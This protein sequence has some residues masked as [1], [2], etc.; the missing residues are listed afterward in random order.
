MLLVP[1][2]MEG[3]RVPRYRDTRIPSPRILQDMASFD[4]NDKMMI[5]RCGRS[6]TIAVHDEVAGL[7]RSCD[8]A[9]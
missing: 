6:F 3:S 4:A 7:P 8:E 1:S 5:V 2:K 9:G